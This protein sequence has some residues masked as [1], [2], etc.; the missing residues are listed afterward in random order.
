MFAD[1]EW[2][3]IG[4][5]IG[6]NTGIMNVGNMGSQYRIAYTVVGD[7]VN[8]GARLEGLTRIFEP[9][10][11]KSELSAAERQW[12][13]DH[14]KA[15]AAYYAGDWASAEAL[16]SRLDGEHPDSRYYVVMRNRILAL[17]T[18][19]DPE[20]DGITSFNAEM[21]VGVS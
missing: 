1:R 6:I 21:S 20:F 10:A 18:R 2:P 15:L 8:L 12:L 14:G 13:S 19:N 16:F 7:A 17:S 9:V 4:I 3:P 11:A 5:G